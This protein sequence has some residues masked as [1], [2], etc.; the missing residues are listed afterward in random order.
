M[1]GREF[2][3][4]SRKFK[5]SAVRPSLE[6]A[7]ITTP[8]ATTNRGRLETQP[9]GSHAKF[10]NCFF[11]IG[12]AISEARSNYRS[13]FDCDGAHVGVVETN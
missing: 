11:N 10:G 2:Q 4:F 12:I 6:V 9:A 8:R 5:G 1:E 13:W 7:R 3:G